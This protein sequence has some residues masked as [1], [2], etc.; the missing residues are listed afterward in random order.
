MSEI[1]ESWLQKAE[2]VIRTKEYNSL[3]ED[4]RMVDMYIMGVFDFQEAVIEE[5]SKE[6]EW[7]EK[8]NHREAE[9][10]KMCFEAMI[11]KVKNLKTP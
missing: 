11:E 6:L 9:I 3:E 1:Y 2:N 8:G 4:D 5:L 10:A 7:A